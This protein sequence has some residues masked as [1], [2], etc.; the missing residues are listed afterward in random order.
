MAFL[1]SSQYLSQTR[2]QGCPGPSGATGPNG[3][4]GATGPQGSTGATGF[5]GSTGATGEQGSTGAF[6]FT[7]PTGAMLY[8]DGTNVTST[9]KL[10]A[11]SNGVII[12]FNATIY[13]DSN[14]GPYNSNTFLLSKTDLVVNSSPGVYQSMFYDLSNF[15]VGCVAYICVRAY[16]SGGP[17]SS[18]LYWFGTIEKTNTISATT[19]YVYNLNRLTGNIDTGILGSQPRLILG[20]PVPPNP[21]N[22]TL[23]F[24]GTVSENNYVVTFR[25][26]QIGF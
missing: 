13:G 9:S 23:Y 19:N 18:T 10:T 1:S 5:S 25:M 16:P 14:N 8:Y 22:E 26:A 3:A 6:S 24:D 20:I 2:L 12:P 4:T 21:V 15:P 17:A 7:G 11:D